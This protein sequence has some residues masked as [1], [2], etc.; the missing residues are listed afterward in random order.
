[1]RRLL[2]AVALALAGAATGAGPVAAHANYVRSNPAAD[3]RLVK[4]PGEVR[5]A[6]SEPPDPKASVL[7]VLDTKGTRVD[8][9]D[10][11]A[12][13]ETN[14]LRV[15]VGPIGDGGYTV[16]WTALSAV[17]G[18][19]TKGTFAFAVGDAPLP[20]LP[21]VPNAAPPP[22]P[23][24]VAGRAL[25]Y[26]GIALALGVALFGL[27]VHPASSE[28]ERRHEREL[29][30]L[31]AGLLVLG[32]AALAL[33]QG[34]RIPPRLALLLG[35]RALTGL[36]I[37]A[38][39]VAPFGARPRRVVILGNA[40]T[41][42][43]TATLVSHAAALGDPKDMVLDLVHV[44]A[45]SAWAGGVAAMLWILL[46]D[47]D[48][49]VAALAGTVRRFSLVAL[50]AVAV[51]VTS[52]TV[53][54][55][56]RLV[57]LQDL[58][59]TP[60]GLA[61]LAKIVLL[62]VTVAFGALN[63]LRFGPRGERRALVRSTVVESGLLGA[64]I[65]AASILTSLA[66]PAQ[67]TGAAFD[68]TRHVGG[69]RLELVVPTS[70]PGRNRYVLR[71]HEGLTPVHSAEKVVLRFTMIEHDMGESELATTERAPGE[72]V[73]EGSPTS[74]FGT[75]RVQTI[76][77]LTGR[78]DVST[79]FTVP[80]SQPSDQG[81]TARALTANAYNLVVF[82][83]PSVPVEGA[84]LTLNVV[85]VDAK[86]DPASSQQIIGTLAA[87]SG[88]TGAP[89]PIAAKEIG[90]GR[91]ELRIAALGRG[92]WSMTIAIGGPENSARYEFEVSP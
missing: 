37:A 29:V 17:D 77:R 33:E 76:V 73:A 58:V 25:S 62:A 64:V 85:V 18:H 35:A 38:A 82:P 87:G 47:R 79:V 30:F 43:L 9:G 36:V 48:R 8:L 78:D 81:A 5:V 31:A 10:T 68:E 67:P 54:S 88:Q 19:E 7:Q 92:K 42:A 6:F 51:L 49:E 13:G 2:L 72:Y 34:A 24:E 57:L 45:V 26:A 22:S 41:A 46:R 84:P 80:V 32:S 11:S 74:M 56:G 16:A 61:L 55:L 70:L 50:V 63:L 44:V 23:L 1:M 53:Q 86:G 71:V 52:G 28:P 40:L 14:G 91:Y 15:G 65:V 27:V 59:E 39:A 83:D 3:A 12:S 89:G 90:P 4:A 69:L 75:W 66:P 60:Y 20:S 21:D